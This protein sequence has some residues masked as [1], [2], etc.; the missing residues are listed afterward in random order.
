MEHDADRLIELGRV[1]GLHGVLGWVRVHSDTEPRER[2]LEYRPWLL[3][4]D[5]RWQ[6]REVETGR[7]HGKGLIAK[8][9]GCEDRDSAAALVAA[10]IAVRRD[11]LPALGPEEYYWA[12]LIGIEVV[13]GDGESLGRVDRLLETGANDVLVVVGDRERL[14]PYLPGRAVQSVDLAARR[15][16]VDWDPEF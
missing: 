9:R 14:I 11:Q 4:I 10:T 7:I 6:S 5:D 3:R 13:T 16:V 8:L 12:D 1:S 15:M 2:I